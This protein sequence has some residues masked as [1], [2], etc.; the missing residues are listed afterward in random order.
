MKLSPWILCSCLASIFSFIKRTLFRFRRRRLSDPGLPTKETGRSGT[1]PSASVNGARNQSAFGHSQADNS[2]VD[3]DWDDWGDGAPMS[4]KIEPT[5]PTVG[6]HPA[7]AHGAIGPPQGHDPTDEGE[8]EPA[9]DY[10]ADMMPSFKKAATIRKKTPQQLISGPSSLTQGLS[11]RLTM[12]VDETA[13]LTDELGAWTESS[14]A[15]EDET[16][17]DLAWEAEQVIREKKMAEREKRAAE[18]R[19]KKMEKEMQRMTKKDAGKLAT[20][21]K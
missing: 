20:K 17:D 16:E 7:T 2:G 15:W 14:S 1:A 21:L 3:L 5:A 12:G 8:E 19:R 6:A 10:F 4:I 11:N 9:V 13:V 18:Q